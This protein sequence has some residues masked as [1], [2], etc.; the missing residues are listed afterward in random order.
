MQ[1]I[2][3]QRDEQLT[4]KAVSFPLPVLALALETT[5]LLSSVIVLIVLRPRGRLNR[6]R[7]D[8]VINNGP[9]AEF[10]PKVSLL[11]STLLDWEA[12]GTADE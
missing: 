11:A 1:H 10:C 9:F 2:P 3:T 7:T 6:P 5:V 8:G 4:H 12:M